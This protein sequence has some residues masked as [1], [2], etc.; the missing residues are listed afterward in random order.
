MK[1]RGFT[2]NVDDVSGRLC[3]VQTDGVALDPLPQLQPCLRHAVQ[4]CMSHHLGVT[5]KV[6]IE[7]YV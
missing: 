7:S 5:A 6:E 1:E 4:V 2:V 3:L